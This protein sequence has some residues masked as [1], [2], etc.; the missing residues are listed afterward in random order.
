[1]TGDP[2]S[3]RARLRL[4]G[5]RAGRRS[6]RGARTGSRARRPRRRPHRRRAAPGPVRLDARAAKRG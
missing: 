1:V 3:S 6:A 4:A 2:R 5:G